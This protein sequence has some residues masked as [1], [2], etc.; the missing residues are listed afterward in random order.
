MPTISACTEN[1]CLRNQPKKSQ[2]DVHKYGIFTLFDSENK[3]IVALCCWGTV[4]RGPKPFRDKCQ[5]HWT[6]LAEETPITIKEPRTR[7][8]KIEFICGLFVW[9]AWWWH[10]SCVQLL[11]EYRM[12]W[13]CFRSAGKNA[14]KWAAACSIKWYDLKPLLN[15]MTNHLLDAQEC[16]FFKMIF[17]TKHLYTYRDHIQNI[18]YIYMTSRTWLSYVVLRFPGQ[19]WM[20]NLRITLQQS[21]NI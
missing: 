4:W 21:L 5:A 18:Q 7:T 17:V 12:L 13:A 20:N 2:K 19:Y 8:K 10:V 9:W 16:G 3:R 1:I 15:G 14:S 11:F 6:N